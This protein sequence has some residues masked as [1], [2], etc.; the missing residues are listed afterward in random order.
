MTMANLIRYRPY[1]ELTRFRWMTRYLAD[2]LNDWFLGTWLDE[3]DNLALDVIE[4]PDALVVKASL[5]GF[6]AKDIDVSVRGNRLVICATHEA[7]AEWQ[8]ARWHVQERR[9]QQFYRELSLPEELK[10][11]PAEAELEN[12]VLTIRIPK[13]NPG[14][15]AGLKGMVKRIL[16]KVTLP[17]LR[18]QS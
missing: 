17:Q 8:D 3:R 16:P 10:D 14:P 11:R 6:Q 18:A 4:Q 5:P 2:W 13:K 7:P 15:L 1:W 12:G 9:F